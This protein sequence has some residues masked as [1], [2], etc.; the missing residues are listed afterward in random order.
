MGVVLGNHH[1]V[2]VI[3]ADGRQI[4]PVAVLYKSITRL[5]DQLA[6]VAADG[7]LAA[8]YRKDVDAVGLAHTDIAQTFTDQG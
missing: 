6:Q 2:A 4:F 5:Q 3:L 7:F 8:Q 1:K